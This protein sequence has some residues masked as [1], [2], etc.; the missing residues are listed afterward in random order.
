MIKST[1]A[2]KLVNWKLKTFS[3]FGVSN[4]G[5]PNSGSKLI[6]TLFKQ[7]WNFT[8]P[9]TAISSLLL[10]AQYTAAPYIKK[11]YHCRFF[12]LLYFCIWCQW[13]FS[14]CVKMGFRRIPY[15]LKILF[16]FEKLRKWLY[17]KWSCIW[18]S[19]RQDKSSQYRIKRKLL[20]RM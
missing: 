10:K 20:T 14:K 12:K 2:E 16:W 8:K 13:K 11:N 1:I 7:T 17:S 5:F 4:L 3:F 19:H 18:E 6:F 15:L 9:K